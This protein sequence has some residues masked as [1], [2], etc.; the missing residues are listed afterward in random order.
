MPQTGSVAVGARVLGR[1]SRCS[2]CLSMAQL[3]T[4]SAVTASVSARIRC[5]ARVLIGAGQ[6]LHDSMGG[7]YGPPV[8]KVRAA[9]RN[10]RWNARATT[11]PSPDRVRWPRPPNPGVCHPPRN[12][13]HLRWCAETSEIH[14]RHRCR[15]PAAHGAPSRVV[16]DFVHLNSRTR[17]RAR[18]Q[19]RDNFEIFTMMDRG[20]SK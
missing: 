3:R 11:R 15:A 17:F 6:S 8:V 16:A 12:V 4:S 9:A 7:Y 2:G 18:N 14:L 1:R 10:R 19:G 20:A 5:T 13:L